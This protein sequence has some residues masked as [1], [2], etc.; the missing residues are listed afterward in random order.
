MQRK[1]K[2]RKLQFFCS[3]LSILEIL[4]FFSYFVYLKINLLFDLM[5][6]IFFVPLL[7]TVLMIAESF[8]YIEFTVL[9]IIT[10]MIRMIYI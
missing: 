7:F 2:L 10:L 3:T 1:T 5:Y 6:F 8:N 9:I 4:L